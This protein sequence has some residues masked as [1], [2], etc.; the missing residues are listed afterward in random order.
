MF[1]SVRAKALP[2]AIA[3]LLAVASAHA[4]NITT[5]G[6]NGRVLD[7]AG[8]PVAG[9]TVTIV[10][11]PSG[12]SKEVTTDAEG[13]YSA[14][15]L[16]VGG[17]FD[18][19]ANEAGKALAEQ[20]DVYLQLGQPSSI[21]LAA[22][23]PGG[24]ATLE[25]VT[26]TASALATTFAA[27][28]KGLSTTISQQQLQ[29]TP[30]G[31]RSIDDIVRL[32]PRIN[33]TDQGTGAVSAL[34]MNNRYNNIAVDGVTQGDPF[35]LNANGLPYLKSP[36]SPETIAEYNISTANYDV[37][38]DAVGADVN[39]VTKSGTNEFHGSAYYSYRNA[40]H[41]VGDAGWLPSNNPGYK[42]NG[43]DKDSTYGFTV[44]GP[45]LKDTLFFF[46]SAEKEKTTGI[47]ADSAN[48]LDYSLGDGASTSTKISPG[49]VQK[50]IDAA[51]KLG[52]KPGTFGGSSA[53]VYDD[54]RY[55]A[56]VDWNIS[57]R[58]RASF[59]YQRSKEAQPAVGGNTPTSIGLSSYV[60]T[61]AIT[62]DNYV[63]HLF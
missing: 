9:A 10:H 38:S 48:G 12:T 40:N 46:L 6:I 36:I 55:L 53:L 2:A 63:G 61:K 3:A 24:A 28:N 37:I 16:R 19:R 15:G 56:K 31:N 23:A 14:Q 44:G 39:A 54:K 49:D 20:H 26:V 32:D 50:V 43:Y 17:P 34:G 52:L 33:V 58:H 21:N 47:G 25:G 4:Q 8:K 60:W 29:A 18:V 7:A 11:V 35:G 13:R 59:T 1:S 27:E 41:L 22:A 62:T 57:D 5:S 45:I 30:Q 51:T 42:Y